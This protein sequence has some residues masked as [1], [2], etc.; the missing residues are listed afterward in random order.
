M[1]SIR[2]SIFL[3]LVCVSASLSFGA[4]PVGVTVEGRV[5]Y[6]EDATRP[7]KLGRYYI[8]D[9]KSGLLAE[10]VVSIEG[11]NLT[12]SGTNRTVVV[13]QQGFQFVPE[14]IAIEAG[15]SV[16]FNNSDDSVHNVMTQDGGEP[17]NVNMGK[18][19]T[20]VQR[21]ANAGGLENPVRIGCIY[22]GGMRAWIY[23]FDHS[24][25][26]VTPA[27]GRF[28]FENVPPGTHTLGFAH[29]AGRLAW[30]QEIQVAGDANLKLDVHLDAGHITSKTKR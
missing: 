27:D 22:H 5:I 21:F 11:S 30:S 3:W 12:R 20:H 16:R 25:F 9:R 17:F 24:R 6:D 29:P 15:D 14:T 13:D 18:G 4:E 28:R 2:N 10:C 7:W 26:T 19:E 23:V 8:K 1:R